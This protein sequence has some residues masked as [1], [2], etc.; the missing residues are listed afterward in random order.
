MGCRPEEGIESPHFPIVPEPGYLPG[1]EDCESQ[2]HDLRRL[3]A[4][5]EPRSRQP[6]LVS[7]FACTQRGE[8]QGDKAQVKEEEPFPFLGVVLHVQRRENEI[9][10]QSDDCRCCLDDDLSVTSGI[11]CSAGDQ[12]DAI[13][14]GYQSEAQQHHIR[15][16]HDIFNSAQ[17]LGENGQWHRL[18][19]SIR[20]KCT[21]DGIFC[22]PRFFPFV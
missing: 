12:D 20:N 1:Q 7:V 9:G 21:T 15:F 16:F 18:P 4:G 8:Q 14:G 11:V 17:S 5:R 13:D 19:E 2:F 6:G 10:K 22:K 3:N